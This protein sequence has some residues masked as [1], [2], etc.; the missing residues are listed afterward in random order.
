MYVCVYI[1]IYIHINYICIIV[2][3]FIH[4]LE[5]I[6]I[7]NKSMA[8]MIGLT[9]KRVAPSFIGWSNNQ[10][11]NRYFKSSLGTKNNT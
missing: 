10:F 5:A 2:Y 11:N 7:I 1:Y 8:S 6:S 4:I 9:S 3:V